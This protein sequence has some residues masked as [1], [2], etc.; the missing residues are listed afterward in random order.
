MI[1]LT[2]GTPGAGK[3]LYTLQRVKAWADKEHRPVFYS[4]IPGLTLDWT[5]IEAEKWYE[6]PPNSI[7]VID[8]C[9]RLFRPRSFGMTVPEYVSRLETHRHQGLDLVVITQHPM[10]IDS[11]VRRLVGRHFH[12]A[13]RFGLKRAT[14]L[15]FESCKENP[16][17]KS[18]DAIR[19]E[20]SYPKEVFSWYKSAEIHTHKARIPARVWLLLALPLMIFGILWWF[21]NR[22]FDENGQVKSPTDNSAPS[23]GGPGS[24]GP[25]AAPKGPL[26]VAAY[27]VALSPRVRGLAH[28]AAYFD[29]VTK[30]TR[31]PFPVGCIEDSTGCRCYSVQGVAYP[32]ESSI[33]Q[34]IIEHGFF[35]WWD[36][37]AVPKERAAK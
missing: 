34:Q 26:T 4:G 23:S 1:E 33:C 3:T 10:L 18:V 31:A 8:E 37:G 20:W 14:V 16:L 27:T 29:E 6:A 17:L 32:T 7:I 25:G 11:N 13:R 19:H 22:H 15:E 21:Y 35:R 36:D 9:Q 30:P 12:V 2:T 5:E 28:T 24:A